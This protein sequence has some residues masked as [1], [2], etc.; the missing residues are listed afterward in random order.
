MYALIIQLGD[1]LAAGNWLLLVL[2]V[3]ILIAAVWVIVES[4]VAL[5]RARKDEPEPDD[6]DEREPVGVDGGSG[7]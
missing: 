5:N 7:E 2:D 6:E 3:I 1:F 4:A